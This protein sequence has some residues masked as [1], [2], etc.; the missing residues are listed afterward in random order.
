MADKKQKKQEGTLL[1]TSGIKHIDK[2]IVDRRFFETYFV[3]S[4]L[5]AT[6]QD[7]E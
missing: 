7:I 4:W 6:E 3:E 1:L 2:E 5:Q